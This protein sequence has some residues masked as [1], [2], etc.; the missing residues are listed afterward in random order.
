[1]KNPKIQKN[2]ELKYLV[3]KNQS[4]PEKILTTWISPDF[5]NRILKIFLNFK[6]ESSNL[7]MK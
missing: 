6:V 2:K 7:K 4:G 5:H 3:G 1:M